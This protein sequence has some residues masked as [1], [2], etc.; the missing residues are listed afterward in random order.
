ME[1]RNGRK[2]TN[3]KQFIE[4]ILRGT[5]FESDILAQARDYNGRFIEDGNGKNNF[6]LLKSKD[7]A[8]MIWHLRPNQELPSKPA[9]NKY[10]GIV[11]K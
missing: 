1:I 9:L 10:L 5:T 3:R 11:I 7:F 4:E 8:A 6:T 2:G